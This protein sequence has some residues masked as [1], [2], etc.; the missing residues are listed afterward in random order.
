MNSSLLAIDIGNS[1]IKACL[2]SPAKTEEN[3]FYFNNL[4]SLFSFIENLSFE[5]ASISSVVPSISKLFLE[6][7]PRDKKFLIIDKSINFNI[8]FSP[9][10]T[11][12]NYFSTIGVDRLCSLEGAYSFF[13]QDS[14]SDFCVIIDF[15]TATTFSLINKYG[16]FL[17]GSISPGLETMFKSLNSNTSLLPLIDE[18]YS[19]G[20]KYISL[21]GNSTP[22]NIISGVYNSALG[23]VTYT[24]DKIKLKYKSNRLSVYITGGNAV[25][26]L[27]MFDFNFI[28]E[29][30]LVLIGIKEITKLNV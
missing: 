15:G 18:S 9:D 17:G 5:M 1:N 2:F 6:Q 27:N 20:T 24:L 13:N 3:I 7:F 30:K 10:G 11:N 12:N 29:P 25:K 22:E 28:Y 14:K 23:I 4:E 19:E 8:K 26:L 16:N 21:L